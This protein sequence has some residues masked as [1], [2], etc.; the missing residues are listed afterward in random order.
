MVGKLHLLNT[1]TTANYVTGIATIIKDTTSI[2]VNIGQPCIVLSVLSLD[3]NGTGHFE[4]DG[5]NSFTINLQV[6]PAEDANFKYSVEMITGTV[7]GIATIL[8]DTTSVIVTHNSGQCK[9]LSVLPLDINGI[10]HFETDIGIN[11]FTINLQVGPAADANFKY[12]I[13]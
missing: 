5:I 2:T 7:T 13:I 3:I 1:G 10:G 8:K 11:S 4:T 9:A 6:G 12:S